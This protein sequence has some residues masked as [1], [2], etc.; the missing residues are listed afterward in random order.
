M[1]ESYKQQCP[2]CE[3][4]VLIKSAAFVGKKME[5]PKCK[6]TF[7]VAKPVASKS[8]SAMS[9]AS[10]GKAK[11][12]TKPKEPETYG[13]DDDD[14]PIAPP[15]PKPAASAKNVSAKSKQVETYGVDD[16]EN[17]Y[18]PHAPPKK[19]AARSDDDDEDEDK[20]PVK[21]AKKPARPP[22]DED[23]DEEIAAAE[24]D[25]DD[26]EIAAAEP[27][28]DEEEA[29]PPKKAPAPAKKAP[30]KPRA[31]VPP[32]DD[33]EEDTPPPAKKTPAKA[34][35]KAA[36]DDE[37]AADSDAEKPQSDEPP[38]EGAAEKTAPKK[39]RFSLNLKGW[40]LASR[41]TAI[42]TGLAIVGILVLGYAGY[43][44]IFSTGPVSQTNLNKG[45]GVPPGGLAKV[46]PNKKG[47]KVD[48]GDKKDDKGDKVD[49]KDDK[50]PDVKPPDK[51]K[52]PSKF[53]AA[54]ALLTNLLP[55]DSE[56]VVRLNFENLLDRDGPF[57]QAAFKYLDLPP[58]PFHEKIME[59]KLGF[60][61]LK[62]D[63]VILAERFGD[64]GWSFAIVHIRDTFDLARLTKTLGLQKVK[65]AKVK[66]DSKANKE[67]KALN[68][69]Y[70]KVANN[71]WLATLG[72]LAPASLPPSAS[73]SR[74]ARARCS[75][76]CATA[77]R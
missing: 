65:D 60:S 7:V 25:D 74:C 37:E 76:N 18:V 29:A 61:P 50:K 72:R 67:Q 14:E 66:L 43:E 12:P 54:D 17:E 49:K 40:K 35:A 53:D 30:V 45:K 75:C 41:K 70:Y 62:V 48:K 44:M 11:A 19:S 51:E 28:D 36:S 39:K 9:A 15:K 20:K 13:V 26:E 8:D 69:E 63:E 5:C 59:A 33:E 56:Q 46:D 64:P 58:G 55:A 2:T 16:T 27:D 1:G 22:V 21:P 71:P 77:R 10:A 6:D 38:E 68:L 73:S 4:M 23:D 34:K 52:T 3:A 31:K 47:D 57:Y 32:D 24:P 42:G